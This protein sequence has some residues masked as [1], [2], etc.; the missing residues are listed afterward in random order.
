MQFYKISFEIVLGEEK[1]KSGRDRYYFKVMQEEAR[2]LLSEKVETYNQKYGDRYIF[3]SNVYD[4]KCQ[5]GLFLNHAISVN[6]EI[7]TFLSASGVTARR[8]D[9]NEV[10]FDTFHQLLREA[11][12]NR[13][14]ISDQCLLEA[15][16]IGPLVGCYDDSISLKE[17]IVSEK[18]DKK[19]IYKDGQRLI[20]MADSLIPEL[21]RIFIGEKQSVFVG[22]PVNYIIETDDAVVQ[23]E[24]VH[25]LLNALWNMGRLE[26]KRYTELTVRRKNRV[27]KNQ[28]EAIFKSNDRGAIVVKLDTDIKFNDD[29]DADYGDFEGLEYI[30]KTAKTNCR[31]V[32]TI[33]CLP[34][35]TVNIKDKVYVNMGDCTFVEMKDGLFDFKKSKKYLREKS[36][37]S[38]VEY[39]EELFRTLKQGH[40]YLSTDLNSIFDEW[41]VDKLKNEIFSQYKD[42]EKIDKKILKEKPKGSAYDELNQMIG[43]DLA[44]K[45]IN[46]ALDSHK[47]ARIFKDKGLVSDSESRHMIFTGNPG[48]AKTTVAR[49]FARIMKDN[50]LVER[51]Q[52]IEVGR[53]DLVGTYLG[54]TAPKVQKRFKEAE[55]G[56]LFIDEA[57]SLVDDRNGSYGDEAI[58]TIVQEMENHRNSVIVIFAGYPDKMEWF[59]DKNPGLRSRIAYH[60]HFDDYTPDELCKI[61]TL[62]AHKKG[63]KLDDSATLKIHELMERAVSEEDFGNGRYARTIIEK[64]KNLHDSRLVRMNVDSVTRDEIVTLS[65][66]DIEIPADGKPS[67]TIGF[68]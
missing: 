23:R 43:L 34:R 56:I 15:F 41:Y 47:A 48:T 3:L 66:D 14:I 60:V 19:S 51:G 59:L 65:A 35:C 18:A 50:D 64:A 11:D 2:S 28:I 29:N 36:K 40:L 24:T 20:S 61:A 63:L 62:I 12:R 42:F 46:Q 32:L 68:V 22:H 10:T 39:D 26:N 8:L 16:G 5:L 13:Y 53:G 38:N 57:Y 27:V 45:I 58:N 1:G 4:L 52:M 25:V 31:N 17:A 33:F 37:Y 49:L 44:K 9:V 30:C 6:E 67:R 7:G 55:G 21:D 54:Q